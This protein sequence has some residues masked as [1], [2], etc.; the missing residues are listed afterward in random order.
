MNNTTVKRIL[1]C[2]GAALLALGAM[3]LGLAHDKKAAEK[4]TFVGH[5][6]GL[7][8]R[9]GAVQPAQVCEPTDEPGCLP[10]EVICR[11]SA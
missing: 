4:K 1:G 2:C 3:G 10:A 6:V 11:V 5:V 8:C 7:D 9:P